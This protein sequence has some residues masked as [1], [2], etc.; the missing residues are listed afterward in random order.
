M[1]I[2]CSTCVMR[3]VACGDCVVS[4]FLALTP[5]DAPAYDLP[6]VEQQALRVLEGA[7]L[8]PPLRLEVAREQRA[9]G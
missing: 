7:G 4:H 3:D 1:V 5:L 6:E 8:V 9:T 2:D